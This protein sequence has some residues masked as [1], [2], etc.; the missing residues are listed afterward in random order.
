MLKKIFFKKIITNYDW[1][2]L[3]SMNCCLSQ[4][5]RPPPPLKTEIFIYIVIYFLCSIYWNQFKLFIV[6]RIGLKIFSYIYQKKMLKIKRNSLFRNK[7]FASKFAKYFEYENIC[8]HIY[9]G[10]LF[11]ATLL[12][13]NG[14]NGEKNGKKLGILFIC[15]PKILQI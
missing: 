9:L 13:P 7:R 11:P 3:V 14:W 1:L 12:F 10:F 5:G 2:P 4:D 6:Y 15:I 8:M